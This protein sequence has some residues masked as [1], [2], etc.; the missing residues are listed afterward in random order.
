MRRFFHFGLVA[1]GG[2]LVQ[3]GLL[4]LFFRLMSLNYSLALVLSVVFAMIFN[5]AIHNVFTFSDRG[6]QGM[7]QLCGLLSFCLACGLG[8]VLNTAVATLCY[9]I[10]WNWALSGLM[11]AGAGGVVNYIFA[12]KWIWKSK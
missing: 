6:L 4:S 5:F 7:A 8:G 10:G 12:S 2:L 1:G 9:Q 3:L 11:G